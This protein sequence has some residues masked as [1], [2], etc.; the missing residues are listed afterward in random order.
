MHSTIEVSSVF[1][2]QILVPLRSISDLVDLETSAQAM[3]PVGPDDQRI[4]DE[5][6]GHDRHAVGVAEKHRLALWN[7]NVERDEKQ[8]IPRPAGL[9]P[10][11][12]GRVRLSARHALQA[13][14]KQF[15]E[16]AADGGREQ[17]VA[18]GDP[19]SPDEKKIRTP[20]ASAGR[21]R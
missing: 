5:H 9:E 1:R 10:G 18:P 8:Q 12:A 7:V 3:A 17:R 20:A 6:A 21:R 15:D 13:G 11:A 14:Q 16:Q 4:N 19:E 2:R